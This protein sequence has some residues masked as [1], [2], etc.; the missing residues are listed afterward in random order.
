[1]KL[2]GSYIAVPYKGFDAEQS[3]YIDIIAWFNNNQTHKHLLFI[4]DDEVYSLSSIWDIINE[5][6]NCMLGPD[7]DEVIFETSIQEIVLRRIIDIKPQFNIKHH[8]AIDKI[9]ELL[10]VAIVMKQPIYFYFWM[11]PV[12]PRRSAKKWS[13]KQFIIDIFN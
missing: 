12:K 11:E 1:M 9:I 5:E 7:E 6:N 4:S 10:N 13:I 3:N 2:R 8:I